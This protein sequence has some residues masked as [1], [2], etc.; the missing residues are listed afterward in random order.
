MNSILNNVMY[1]RKFHASNYLHALISL[2][3]KKPV[4]SL[5]WQNQQNKSRGA[6][7]GCP[8]LHLIWLSSITYIPACMLSSVMNGA[9]KGQTLQARRGHSM[10]KVESTWHYVNSTR[11]MLHLSIVA[12]VHLPHPVRACDLISKLAKKLVS[13]LAI[14]LARREG[15]KPETESTISVTT[16][17]MGNIL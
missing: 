12:H 4:I 13:S 7:F 9:V 16:T 15:K 1:T 17:C 5:P 8:L 6:C 11:M 14:S 10:V 2:S 3:A